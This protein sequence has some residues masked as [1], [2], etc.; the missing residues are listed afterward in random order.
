[1]VEMIVEHEFQLHTERDENITLAITLRRKLVRKLRKKRGLGT[2]ISLR[3]QTSDS[4]GCE[5]SK[6]HKGT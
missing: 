2:T 3:E 5:S 1:M 6:V 4:D